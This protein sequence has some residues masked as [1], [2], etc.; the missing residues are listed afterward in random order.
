MPKKLKLIKKMAAVTA[1]S[2]LEMKVTKTGGPVSTAAEVGSTA[3]DDASFTDSQLTP[4][5]T[6]MPLNPTNSYAI[7]WT[8]AF[9]KAGTATLNVRV[10]REDGT[11]KETKP[12]RVQGKAKEKFFRLVLVP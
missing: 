6:T 3:S 1:P 4:G 7:A 9:V 8:G 11:V 12:V 10:V 5:P 2:T